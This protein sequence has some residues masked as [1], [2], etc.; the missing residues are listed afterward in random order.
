MAGI[1]ITTVGVKLKI[2]RVL[3]SARQSPERDEPCPAPS[4]QARFSLCDSSSLVCWLLFVMGAQGRRD[5]LA[6][7]SG[8]G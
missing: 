7:A 2:I 5:R 3:G 4:C 8:T 1:A 6:T